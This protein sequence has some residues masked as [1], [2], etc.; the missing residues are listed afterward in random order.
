MNKNAIIAISIIVIYMLAVNI[1]VRRHSKLESSADLDGFAV[2]GRSFPWYMVM[3]TILATWYTGS[4]FTGAFGY[5]VSFGALALYDTTQV[6]IGL[7]FLY[8]LGPRI[9]KWG[10]VH[11]LYNLPDFI[12]L[13]YRDKTLSLVLACYTILIGFPWTMMAFKTFGYLIHALTYETVSMNVGIII[14]V[15]FI[16]SYSLKGGQKGVVTSDFI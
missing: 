5:A 2:G 15:I 11:N 9:W 8:V 10:K 3:F 13:R 14:S 4:C 7:V 12:E 6:I 16:L 1:Y